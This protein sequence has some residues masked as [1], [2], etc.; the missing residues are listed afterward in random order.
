MQA[1]FLA[2][3][4]MPEALSALQEDGAVAVGGGTQVGILLRQGML[5]PGRLVWLGR[6]DGLRTISTTNG[7]L[8]IGAG[9]T[10]SEIAASE[11]ARLLHPMLAAAAT[12]VGNPR[13]RAVATLGGHL[14]HA[15]PRQDLLPVLLALDA[16]AILRGPAGDREIALRDFF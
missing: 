10:L 3:A 13:V 11:A 5:E 14:V 16:A 6:V 7:W 8:E 15:D 2:P 1:E 9:A 12:R 4:S